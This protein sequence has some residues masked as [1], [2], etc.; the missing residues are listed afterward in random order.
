M[1]LLA[2]PGLAVAM[3]VF[4]GGHATAHVRDVRSADLQSLFGKFTRLD[5]LLTKAIDR[6][7]KDEH[8]H[9]LIDQI[10][11]GKHQIVDQQLSAPIDGVSGSE[12][13]AKLDC[14]DI[15][16]DRARLFDLGHVT[17]PGAFGGSKRTEVITENL[18][19]AKKC[20][21]KLE[22]DLH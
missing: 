8:V 10:V 21:Q 14:A 2:V 17:I 20:K 6:A 16:L 9:G 7:E 15:H 5:R 11:D 12:W 13:Y 3:A 4:A 1:L 19:N 22:D 18:K